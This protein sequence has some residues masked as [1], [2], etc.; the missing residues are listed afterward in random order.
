MAEKFRMLRKNGVGAPYA[1][2]EVL[3]RRGDMVECM[4]TKEEIL[5]ASENRVSANIE[6]PA[7]AEKAEPEASAPAENVVL[8][9]FS[10]VSETIEEAPQ[11][12]PAPR[13]AVR[14]GFT[15]K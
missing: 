1:Y 13:P 4:M 7:V 3:R 2:S 9:V 14:K 5:E 11:V 12:K 10:E 8:D 6:P 15:K